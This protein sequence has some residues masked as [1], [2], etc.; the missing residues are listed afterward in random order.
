MNT[1]FLTGL[2]IREEQ[3]VAVPPDK[4]TF[5][6]KRVLWNGAPCAGKLIRPGGG[7]PENKDAFFDLVGKSCIRWN[8]LSHPYILQLFGMYRSPDENLPV[9]VAELMDTDLSSL[10]RVRDK[11]A[12]PLGLKARLLEQ[13]LLGVAH[14]HSHSPALVHG[15]ISA[16][17]VVV[18]MKRWVGKLSEC[19]LREEGPTAVGGTVALFHSKEEESAYQPP[20]AYNGV[21]TAEGDVFAYGVLVLHTIGHSLPL[22]TPSTQ[23]SKGA[24]EMF[25]E[26]EAR[27][28]CLEFFAYSELEQFQKIIQRCLRYSPE[29]R[30]DMKTLCAEIQSISRSLMQEDPSLLEQDQR[31]PLRHQ[32]STDV[33]L[34]QVELENAIHRALSAEEQGRKWKEEAAQVKE[35]AEKVAIASS[36]D[37]EK[38]VLLSAELQSAQSGTGDAGREVTELRTELRDLL[39][40]VE[41]LEKDKVSLTAAKE[42]LL[43][44]LHEQDG[45]VSCVWCSTLVCYLVYPLAQKDLLSGDRGCF[46]LY[47]LTSSNTEN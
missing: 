8:Q 6:W 19:C 45:H 25:S 9:L 23:Q 28:H 13:V 26:F 43:G 39:E 38:L 16:S 11:G 12:L 34:L 2:R 29:D 7:A 30:M 4:G 5:A 35:A 22:P 17:K 24:V 32:Q 31:R 15:S 41:E 18:D 3:P 37:K 44:R 21:Y 33:E 47:T 46:A 40:R 10:L 1:T 27:K 36:I 42:E 20:E 14:L